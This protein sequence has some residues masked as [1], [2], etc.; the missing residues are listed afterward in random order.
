MAQRKTKSELVDVARKLFAE[1]G[2]HGT[3]MND[4]ADASGRGRRTLYTYFK[5]KEDI[6][7]AVISAELELFKHEL[8]VARRINLPPE[9]K[10]INLIYVHLESLK[11]V[12]LRNGS[13]RAEFFRDIW[14]VEAARQPLDTYEQELIQEILDEG[15]SKGQFLIPHTPTMAYLL[16]NAIKGMEV[17][18]ISGYIRQK[19]DS[20]FNQIRDNMMQL[21]LRGIR[22]DPWRPGMEDASPMIN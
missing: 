22:R 9:P 20:K 21:L 10:L 7:K 2:L 12:V 17:P 16:H 11:T 13:L 15:V 6:Y 19:S 4:I 3:T 14:H 5:S 8:E 1:R 18:Y